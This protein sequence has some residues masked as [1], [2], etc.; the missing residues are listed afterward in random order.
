MPNVTL[1]YTALSSAFKDD[2][3]LWH[4]HLS[5]SCV[6]VCGDARRNEVIADAAIPQ[7]L[8]DFGFPGQGAEIEGCSNLVRHFRCPVGS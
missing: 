3:G 1:I 6:Y 8:K 4:Y 2:K 5:F 7:L